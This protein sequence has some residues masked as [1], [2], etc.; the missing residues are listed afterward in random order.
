MP[1]RDQ[2]PGMIHA[3]PDLGEETSATIDFMNGEIK[4]LW[5]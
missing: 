3:D 1:G 4:R 5:P 2:G